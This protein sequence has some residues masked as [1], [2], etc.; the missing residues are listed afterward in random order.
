MDIPGYFF[1]MTIIIITAALTVLLM[2]NQTAKRPRPSMRIT[3]REPESPES[4]DEA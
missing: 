2:M 1:T 4:H 3:V